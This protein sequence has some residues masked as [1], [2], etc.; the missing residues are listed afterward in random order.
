[1]QAQTASLRPEIG[2]LMDIVY[3]NASVE[4]RLVNAGTLDPALAQEFGALGFVGRG[5][6]ATFDARR[7][8]PYPPYDQLPVRVPVFHYGDI[9]ARLRV[10]AEEILVSFDLIE[11]LLATLPSG[12]L[13]I[14]WT[15]PAADAEGLGIVEGW[16]GEIFTFLRFRADGRIARFF[17]R[18]PSW[19]T[20]PTLEKLIRDNI[21]PDF[22][23]CNKSV[24]GSY[25]G[26]DL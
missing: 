21:V 26:H 4:D 11:R 12:P 9:A 10:R 19:L 17:P 16:R 7:D 2:K 14:D 8:A 1:M 13:R 24:N 6:N 23:V 20:W 15:P 5:A 18:D 22:P 25:S 3:D